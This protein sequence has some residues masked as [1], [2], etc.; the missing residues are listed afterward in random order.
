MKDRN[1]IARYG[2]ETKKISIGEKKRIGG[3]KYAKLQKRVYV[4]C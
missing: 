4:T 3:A 2:N 1:I